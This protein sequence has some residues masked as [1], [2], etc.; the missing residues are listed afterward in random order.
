[1]PAAE[2]RRLLI[3]EVPVRT[4]LSRLSTEARKPL[5]LAEVPEAELERFARLGADHVWLMGVW[6]S[7]PSG[8]AIARNHAGLLEEYRRALPD[9]TLADVGGSPFAV[10]GTEVDPRLGGPEA[11]EV[12]RGR[13]RSHGLGLILDFVPNH[14]GVDHPWVRQQPGL[15]VQGT[16]GDLAGAPG[17]FFAAQTAEGPRVI[18]HGRDP[19]FPAWT[20]TAQLDVARAAT[21]AALARHL[22]AVAGQCDGVRCDMA[23][24]L[25]ETVFRRT[26]G[27]R[28]LA[29]VTPVTPITGGQAGE[30]AQGEAWSELIVAVRREHPTFLLIAEAYWGLEGRLRA[31]GFDLVYDKTY[32][33][34][35]IRGSA[36]EVR[37]HLRDLPDQ[38]GTVRFL[39]NHDEPRAAAALPWDRHRAASVLAVTAPGAV[40]LHEGQTEGAEL[41]V[42]VQLLHGPREPVRP[43]VREH[44]GRLLA[45][46]RDPVLRQGSWRL[47]PV[48]PAWDGNAAWQGFLAFEWR[49]GHELRLVV[50]NFAPAQGQCYVVL[51]EQRLAGR[52]VELLDRLGPAVYQRQGNELLTRGLYLDLP[53][54]GYHLFEVG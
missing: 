2:P 38:S 31:L 4:W 32:T 47:L 20:D 7:G 21:R 54:W 16:T 36:A 24:L 53:G 48:V 15:Y 51:G 45:A 25:L 9:F 42:P 6:P 43:E 34:K 30:P 19:N 10:A 50:V 26:W 44:Y 3:H 5:T 22:L 11:L 12:L 35:L 18:A 39:E 14:T 29:P 41:R 23:M 13:L 37:A 33:D 17:S 52:Q 46:L 27:N 28:P 8:T 1:V 49:L 40:L